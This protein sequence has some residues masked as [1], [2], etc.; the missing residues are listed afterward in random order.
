MKV[1]YLKPEDELLLW[2]AIFLLGFMCG[3]A[4]LALP[5]SNGF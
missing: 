4:D 2:A 3:R 1:P 5:S